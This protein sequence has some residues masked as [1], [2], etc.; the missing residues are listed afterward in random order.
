QTARADKSPAKRKRAAERLADP[1]VLLEIAR[2][3]ADQEVCLAALGNPHL[4]DVGFLAEVAKGHKHWKM[5]RVA[6]E[7][8]SDQA[9]LGFVAKSDATVF[10]REAAIARLNDQA[11]LH[12]IAATDQD[13]RLRRLALRKIGF[14]SIRSAGYE[15]LE[16][17]G[18]R[19]PTCREKC[20]PAIAA[21]FA[22]FGVRLVPGEPRPDLRLR[23]LVTGAPV[24]ADDG[25]HAPGAQATARVTL[26]D[27]RIEYVQT[28]RFDPPAL[29]RNVKTSD[30]DAGRALLCAAV[31]A[32][33]AAALL[34]M[35]I[36]L[37]SDVDQ[38]VFAE[39][40]Q[41]DQGAAM[42]KAAVRRLTRQSLLI[43][44][45]R[46]DKNEEVREIAVRKLTGALLLAEIARHDSVWRLRKAAIENANL[47][48]QVLLADAARNDSEGYV[49]AAAV[50]RLTD[51]LLLE[52]IGRSTSS[53]TIREAVN[54]RLR[55][56]RAGA[57]RP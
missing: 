14:K 30:R 28:Y 12:E 21:R 57:R 44:V 55:E 4:L 17:Y 29:A 36:D 5:R 46:N 47:K 41:A 13:E 33:L 27:Y 1:A 11:L 3:D 34:E 9:V 19:G 16:D 24:P 23:I 48:D 50:L 45:A 42:R 56:L 15:L 18:A 26:P 53:A 54:R 37:V 52:D 49:R 22:L 25:V 8:I 6:V 10:V 38:V 32:A 51:P 2:G 31:E 35:G 40:A 7:R 20:A 43:D 39:A